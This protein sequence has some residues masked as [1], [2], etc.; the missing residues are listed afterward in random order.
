MKVAE[1]EHLTA[2]QAIV[3]FLAAQSVSATAR[4]N[5]SSPGCS[6]SSVAATWPDWA[7]RSRRPVTAFATTRPGTSRRWSTRP[8]GSPRSPGTRPLAAAYRHVLHWTE[9]IG[10]NVTLTMPHQWQRRFNA[11]NIE[12][13]PRFDEP[14]PAAQLEALLE[15]I[16]DFRRAFEPQGLAV[17]EFETYG[18]TVRTPAHVHRRVL[19]SRPCDRRDPPAQSGC[20]PTRMTRSSCLARRVTEDRRGRSVTSPPPRELVPTPTSCAPEN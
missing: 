11:S 3:R 13:A 9:L 17:E 16:P 4:N 14:V 8:Q 6:E 18:A 19:G 1:T 2:T 5:P 12:M 7:R 15:R 20:A 10:G